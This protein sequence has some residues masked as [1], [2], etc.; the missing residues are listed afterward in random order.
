M[1]SAFFSDLLASIAERGRSVLKLT[2]W[3]RDADNRAGSLADMCGALL[4]G[5]GEASGVALASE[6]LAR[7]R[8]LSDA[9]KDAF[10]RALADEFGPDR[11]RVQ[12]AVARWSAAGERSRR[13]ARSTTPP[14]R[15]GRSCSAASIARPAARRRWWRCAPTSSSRMREDRGLADGRPRFPASVR[16]VVQSRLSGAAPD[17][18]VLA[19]RDPGEDHPLRGRPRNPRLGR[20]APAHRSHGPAL[21]RLLPSGAGRRAADLRRSRADPGPPDAI[22]PLLAEK[23]AHVA[24]DRARAAAFYSISNCQ[25]GLDGRDLRQFP[26]QAGGRGNP[27]RT[28]AHRDLRHAVAG[29]R[30]S[31]LGRDDCDDPAVEGLAR[32]GRENGADEDW[33]AKPDSAARLRKAL[34]P[35]AAY[36]FLKAR[37]ADGRVIDPVARFHLGNGARLERINWMGDLSAKG[38]SESYGVMVNYSTISP[39]SSGTTRPS[40]IRASSSP[41]A[42]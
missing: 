39:R 17:R 41:R 38:L 42:R 28:A 23:R 27:A 2:A 4:T 6:I 10:F 18:L 3:P 31:R 7:Y 29:P 40:P 14:S 19:R 11:Q 25:K 1:D 9:D 22:A 36:Y 35:L 26:H 15:A 13:R 20:S 5:R 12:D 37:R 32:E 30:L 8:G 33:A 16:L 21:L 24:Q 34:E